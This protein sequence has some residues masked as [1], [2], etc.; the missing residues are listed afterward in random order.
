[1]G[2]KNFDICEDDGPEVLLDVQSGF[3]HSPDYPKYYGNSRSC[4]LTIQVPVNKHLSIY[5]IN[6][7]LEKRSVFSSAI[8]DYLKVDEKIFHGHSIIPARIFN[9][10]GYANVRLEFVSDWITSSALASPKGFLL[11][12][13]CNI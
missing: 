4:A 1:M 2:G 8:K 13:E 6:M 9:Q 7:S 10:S 11:Y 12:F 3:I 5:L